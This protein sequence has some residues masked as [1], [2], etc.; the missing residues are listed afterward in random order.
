MS[1]PSNPTYGQP[2]FETVST[3]PGLNR[4]K[5]NTCKIID[6]QLLILNPGER[7]SIETKNRELAFDLLTGTATIRAGTHTFEKI[8]GRTSIFDDF[9]TMVY[10]GC[11]TT[12]EIEAHDRLEIGIGSAPSSTPIE[13]YIVRP[14]EVPHGSWGD[15]DNTRR[16]FRYMIN[17]DRPSESLWFA[18]VIVRDGRWATYPPHK[19]EEVPGDLFQEEMYFYKIDPVEGFGFCGH[20]G[21]EVG[22]DYAFMIR[23]NTIHKMPHGYHTVTAAPGYQVFYLAVYA[24]YGKDHRPSVHPDHAGF[25]QNKMPENPR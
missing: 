17:K 24:G 5:H 25:R 7:F 16:H 18:E 15:G 4:L 13:P 3:S 6:F 21:G 8:G 10:A 11:G 22:S 23:N 14:Q 2:Y 9:P 20:F 1:S 12:V 19:H